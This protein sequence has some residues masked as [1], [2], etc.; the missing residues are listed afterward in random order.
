[1]Q[2]NDLV[3]EKH[4]RSIC[5][6]DLGIV[7]SNIPTHSSEPNE[8]WGTPTVR[9]CNLD[10]DHVCGGIIFES[11]KMNY[12]NYKNSCEGIFSSFYR[13]VAFYKEYQLVYF[14]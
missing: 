9:N 8:E 5:H 1:M 2:N 7:C 11:A 6:L 13:S 3:D 4:T 10:G 12:S 14:H